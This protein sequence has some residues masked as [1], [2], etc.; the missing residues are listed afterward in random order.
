MGRPVKEA[1]KTLRIPRSSY[2]RWRKGGCQEPA[3]QNLR[4]LTPEEWERI[5]RVKE[6]HPE[7]RHRRIQ[8]ALQAEGTYVSFSSVYKRLKEQGWEQSF[9]RRSSPWQEPRY[10][11]IRRNLLWGAD[12]TKLRIAGLRWYLLTL[13]DFFSRL[14]VAHRIVPSVHAGCVKALYQ[15]GLLSQGIGL[16]SPL[17]PEMRVDR[18][19]P[20]TSWVTKEFFETIGSKLSFARVRRPTD[21]AITE[22]FYGTAKQ[23]EI[24]LVGDYPDALSAQ[25]EIGSYIHHYN[26]ERPHQALWNFTPKTVHDLNNKTELLQRLKEIKRQTLKKRRWYW[27]NRQNPKKGLQNQALVFAT[28]DDRVLGNIQGWEKDEAGADRTEHQKSDS[29]KTQ[30]L[31]H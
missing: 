2:Y 7:W 31:S 30:I 21:N 6:G 17:K 13:I 4:I 11:V 28:T 24:Y 19:S 27:L 14:L 23:E 12:W 10:E 8:G 3:A 5:D 22:R 15:E 1:A 26:T 29:I 25:R 9:K 18:G 20:N 16:K